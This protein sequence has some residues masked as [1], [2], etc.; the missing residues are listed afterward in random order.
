M[1][2]SWTAYC[3]RI[4]PLLSLLLT[5]ICPGAASAATF[6][7]SGNF[8]TDSDRQS[9]FFTVKSAGTVVISTSSYASGGFDPS[10]A[11]FDSGGNLIATN[12]DGGCANVPATP[13]RA[14]AGTPTFR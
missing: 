12:R 9:Y 7:F 4:N 14:S 3:R 2:Q 5:L 13:P 10:L 6:S 8:T 11:V 1:A